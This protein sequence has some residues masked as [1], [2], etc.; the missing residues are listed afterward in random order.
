VTLLASIHD[1]APPHLQ[2]VR[3]LRAQLASWGVPRVTLL[4]VPDFHGQHPLERAPETVAWLRERAA[5]GD[6]ICLHGDVHLQQGTVG[7]RGDRA[8]AALFTDG[9]GECLSLSDDA[10]SRM[11]VDGRRRLEE[12]VGRPVLG[13]VAP[14]W[15]EPRG[16]GA[17]LRAAG[18]RWH[19]GSL[20]VERLAGRTP[21]EPRRFYLTPVIGFATRTDARLAAAL[22]WAG[23]LAPAVAA[24]HAAGCGPEL[25]RIALHPGDAGSPAVLRAAEHA[26]K[27][28]LDEYAP[29]T[30]G[31]SL[32]ISATEGHA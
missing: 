4:A 7:P 30:Y 12:L 20:W 11:L 13:F 18:F 15:L 27:T 8:R 29:D 2:A 6:E 1:V 31:H 25:A 5:A 24:A 32:G 28:L 22:A 3:A 26:V 9:E 23:A 10:R 16:F 14:A 17:H 19:E 21:A